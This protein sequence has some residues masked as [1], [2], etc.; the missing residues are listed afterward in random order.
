M[1][2]NSS[3]IAHSTCSKKECL[4]SNIFTDQFQ[5]FKF[6]Y[7]YMQCVNPHKILITMIA[8]LRNSRSFC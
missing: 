2:L 1:I 5:I 7:Y 3:H 8:Y 4:W 6:L